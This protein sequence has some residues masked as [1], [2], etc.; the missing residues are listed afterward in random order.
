MI[1]SIIISIFLINLIIVINV[2]TISKI[3]NLYDFPDKKL[4]IHKKKIPLIGG[5]ILILNILFLIL[6]EFIFR[7]E[8]F[9]F[10]QS[11]SEIFS[12][13][14][15]LLSFFILGFYDD[16]YKIKPFYKFFFS[17]LI[18]L[19]Y[20][21]TNNNILI[22]SFSLSIYEHK[23][24]LETFSVFFSIFCIIVLINALNFFDGINGQSL[25][26]FLLVFSYLLFKTNRYEFYVFIIIIILFCLFLNLRNQIF[27]GDNGVYVLSLILIT[28][29]I[30]ENNVYKNFT[31]ADEIF[32]LLLLPGIDLIRLTF[33][34][35]IKK[36]NPF[37]GDRNHIH[38]LMIKK[39]S[40][41]ITNIL[42]FLLSVFPIFLYNVFE[43]NFYAIFSTFFVIYILLIN[44]LSNDS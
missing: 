34:R 17:I 11:L 9:V 39:Y 32:F 24:F 27:L 36:K 10:F 5:S 23:I 33:L 29:I 30:Y 20:I 41:L 22:K 15:I 13:L 1:S 26:F 35:L 42:L 19:F 8:I 4:K 16:K 40:L 6:I 28:S 14:L 31:Y 44:N 7:V 21:I 18:S 37:Y 2:N 43:L 38:H 25:I 3:I 12:F